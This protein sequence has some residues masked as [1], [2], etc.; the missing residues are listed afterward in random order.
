MNDDLETIEIFYFDGQRLR[1]GVTEEGVRCPVAA[2]AAKILGYKGGARNAIARLPARMKGVAQVSTPGG[3]QTMVVLTQAGLNRLVIN[4]TLD[5]AEEIQDWLAEEVM[6][7]IQA[8]GMYVRPGSEGMLALPADYDEAL[9]HLVLARRAKKVAEA[10]LAITQTV[11]DDQQAALA[12]NE[13]KVSYYDDHLSAEGG[14]LVRTVAASFVLDGLLPNHD[15]E[16]RLWAYLEQQDYVYYAQA[17]DGGVWR[18]SKKGR[19]SGLFRLRDNHFNRNGVA[20]IADPTITISAFS[21]TKLWDQL[22]TLRDAEPVNPGRA[23]NP[24]L[25]DGDEW[26]EFKRIRQSAR[27]TAA[28]KAHEGDPHTVIRLSDRLRKAE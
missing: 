26:R 7:Q 27:E 22:R 19:E 16:Q 13:P 15:C 21:K 8:T 2:D 14:M 25:G 11:V 3:A 10:Q 1:T 23:V 5:R 24:V 6:P 20:K 12:E 9:E 17:R 28:L 4:S 18:L